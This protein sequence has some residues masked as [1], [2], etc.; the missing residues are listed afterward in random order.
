MHEDFSREE[1][2][3]GSSDRAFGLLVAACLA[4]V[5]LAPLLHEPSQPI[6]WWALALST[7]FLVLALLWSAALRPLNRLWLKL[8][9][10]LYRV[11]S[12]LALGLL[13][14]LTVS[15]VGLLMRIFGKDPL[16]LRR[17][18]AAASYW[19][20]REPPGPPPESMKNQ[21]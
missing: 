2:V 11:I 19:I 1:K 3:E 20:R 14:Y 9:L 18:P 4:L 10:L 21:F 6:R 13:F 7:L 12:P 5:A 8:G 17:D 16:R 15:P